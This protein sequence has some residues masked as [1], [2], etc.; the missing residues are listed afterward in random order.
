M[1]TR[2]R[3]LT[4]SDRGAALLETAVTLPLILF[5]AVAILEFGHAFQTWQVL[6][7]AA[8]EGARVAV[9]PGTADADVTSR[10]QSYLASGQVRRADEAEVD[11]E[12]NTVISIGAGTAS[13]SRVE[14]SYPFEFFV[15][16]PVANLVVEGSTVGQAFT[17][18]ATATMRNES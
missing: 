17:M 7:N 18:I 15:L 2:L 1:R 5:V 8:R 11:I 13:A 9:L 12:R 6:T 3:R 14:V 16:Q 4:G 10:I